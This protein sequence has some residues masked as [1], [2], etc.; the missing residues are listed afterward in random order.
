MERAGVLHMVSKAMRPVL[1]KLFPRCAQDPVCLRCLCGNLS[2]DV[3]GLGNAATPFGIR[4]VLRMRDIL[5]GPAAKNE[6]YLFIVLNTASLQLIP[7]TAAALRA[8]LGAAHA[9]DILPA[10]WLS[11]ACSVLAGILAAKQFARVFK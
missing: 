11:S 9:F 2:A 6:L 5:S 10:V 3:L 8:S 1:G 4:A 7:S